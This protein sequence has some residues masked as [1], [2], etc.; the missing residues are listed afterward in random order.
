MSQSA[1]R[2]VA[3]KGPPP[4]IFK[5]SALGRRLHH[6]RQQLLPHQ[7]V[8]GL[9]Q[10]PDSIAAKAGSPEEKVVTEAEVARIEHEKEL[11]QELEVVCAQSIVVIGLWKTQLRVD[12]AEELG[13]PVELGGEFG[14]RRVRGRDGFPEYSLEVR[15]GDVALGDESPKILDREPG[16]DERVGDSNPLDID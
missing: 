6:C 4:R 5:R 15:E 2:L 1:R 8:H 10:S 9:D 14:E 3:T 11:A 12:T 16:L 13:V 7:G